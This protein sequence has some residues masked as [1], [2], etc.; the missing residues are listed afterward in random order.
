MESSRSAGPRFPPALAIAALAGANLS[1][2]QFVALT[3]FPSLVGSNELVALIVLSAY[4]LGL[5]VGYLVSDKLGRGQLL[6]IGAATLALHA[7]LPFSARWFAGT[8]WR[9]GHQG[10]IPPFLFLLALFG[11]TPF[12]AVFLPRLIQSLDSG[13]PDRA[14]DPGR[15]LV[16]IYAT[17]ILGSIAGLLLSVALTPARI[18]LILTAHL[19]GIL[20]IL[21]LCA[22]GRQRTLVKIVLIPLA[23]AYLYL[24]PTLDRASL[25]YFYQHK[26]GLRRVSLLASE[27][28]PYQRVD[29]FE[30][31]QGSGTSTYLYLNGN[32]FYGETALNQHNLLV[33]ILPNLMIPHPSNALVV[34]GGS[35]DC[36]RYLA[37]VTGQL[38]VV[39]IDET[40]ARLARRHLQEPRGGFPTNWELVIDDGKHFLGNWSGPPFDVISVDVPIPSH[41]QTAM[42][43][44]ERFFR[45]A[46]GRLAPGGIFSIALSGSYSEGLS[47]VDDGLSHL[48]NRVVA[49][50][51]KTFPRVA[52]VRANGRAFAWASDAPLPFTI[53]QL[54][55]RL[56]A[57]LASSGA[58]GGFGT[59]TV[60]LLDDATVHA[61]AEGF[62][63][64]GD[65]DM[66]VVLRLSTN[67]LLR[68]FYEPN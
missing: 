3:E 48:G 31:T 14:A 8:L 38:R 47:S 15:R 23:A 7:T 24:Y 57:F 32:F 19:C 63:P 68:R 37:P 1:L 27:F 35:L 10:G 9:T 30:G 53:D 59:P 62:S 26:R 34:A 11:I 54:R 22:S 2:I 28:S 20:G 33:S 66:Q 36:A 49:G 44:S 55:A 51:L 52:V 25:E 50:L 58:R 29:L 45:L 39:E 65:A 42:L 5:S 43:H 41:L 4:F 64:I 60:E 61:R 17:E 21:Y 56:D 6:A 18:S 12:Y 46:R 13:E 40:V 67:K 16:R